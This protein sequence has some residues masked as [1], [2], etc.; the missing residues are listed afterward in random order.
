MAKTARAVLSSRRSVT[1]RSWK[2][3]SLRLSTGETASGVCCVQ[4]CIS[5]CR[6][7]IGGRQRKGPRDEECRSYK[8]K[9]RELGCSAW[10]REDSVRNLFNMNNY[11]KAGSKEDRA[12]LFSVVLSDKARG[13]GC[14]MKHQEALLLPSTGTGS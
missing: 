3:L 10:K 12:R 11:L 1:S 9:L 7:G 13:S 2:D 5:Q 14:K 8:E 4:L 6:T